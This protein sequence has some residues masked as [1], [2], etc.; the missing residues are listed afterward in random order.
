MKKLRD[1]HPRFFRIYNI[2]ALLFNIGMTLY[3]IINNP[4]KYAK[5]ARRDDY[6]IGWFNNSYYLYKTNITE[7]ENCSREASF[8]YSPENV[9]NAIVSRNSQNTQQFVTAFWIGLIF[10]SV[11]KF[12][13]IGETIMSLITNQEKEKIYGGVKY[14][15]YIIYLKLTKNYTFVTIS[16]MISVF[17]YSQL[18]LEYHSRLSTFVLNNSTWLILLSF[19]GFLMVIIDFCTTRIKS[20]RCNNQCCCACCINIATANW[21]GLCCAWYFFLTFLI[22]LF[23][24]LF[25]FFLSLYEKGSRVQGILVTL[26]LIITAGQE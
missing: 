11:L 9:Y 25:V 12:I 16:F 20:R 4:I 13:E 1:N 22:A 23:V 6:S 5:Y 26:N 10:A 15:I 14:I 19:F 2:I 8:D 17:D 24:G 21:L 3:L 18:C 7:P